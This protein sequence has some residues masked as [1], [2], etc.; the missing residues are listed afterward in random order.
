M[1]K[2]SNPNP[3]VSSICG[4]V[5]GGL[6]GAAMDCYWWAVRRLPGERPEQKPKSGDDNQD[7]PEPSTQI[8]ADR[9][10]TALTGHHVPAED[11]PA[12]GI[13]V[14]YATSLF[15][16]GLLG[17]AASRVPRLGLLA[18]LL[19][20]AAIWLL[21]DEITLRLLDIAPDPRKVP[22][23]QHLQ[24]LGAHFVYGTATALVTRLLLRVLS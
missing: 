5:A 19:Y 22:A 11:K 12:A 24:A 8:I 21:L 23:R 18:G 14:H 16:G 4:L 6:A 2:R 10:T 3:I 7:K 9:V 15:Y 20:G 17:A 1:Q 13:A